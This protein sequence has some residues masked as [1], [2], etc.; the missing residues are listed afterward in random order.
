MSGKIIARNSTVLHFD[1]EKKRIEVNITRNKMTLIEE[2]TVIYSKYPGGW[3][4]YFVNGHRI[5]SNIIRNLKRY[6]E[7]VE[8]TNEYELFRIPWDRIEMMKKAA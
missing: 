8:E 1:L 7:F 3:S 4:S 6:L 2:E 5:S